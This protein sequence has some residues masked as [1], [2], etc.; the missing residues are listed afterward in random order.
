MPPSPWIGSTSTA[1]VWPS[2]DVGNRGEIIV[3]NINESGNH[4]LEPDVVLGLSR[5][6]QCGVRASV[7]APFHRDDFES[8]LLMA[9]GPGQLD[10]GLI[11]LGTTVAEEALAPERP[12]RE[13]LRE[14][15]WAS[16]YQ[17]F[18]TWINCPTWSRTAS[19]THGG[20]WP[21]RLQPHPGK[22]SR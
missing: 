5:R 13:C 1:A 21:R 19:T 3:R 10:S 15:P 22:K 18:G 20:Q 9:K 16:I 8:P 14:P 7:K 4:R 6:G 12:L 11:G 17:V 2:S